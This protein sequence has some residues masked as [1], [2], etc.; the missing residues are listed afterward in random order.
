MTFGAVNVEKLDILREIVKKKDFQM[1]NRKIR[2]QAYVQNA[3][4]EITGQINADLNIIKMG[5][6]CWEM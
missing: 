5:L 1:L 4:K 6:L 2:L 3:K